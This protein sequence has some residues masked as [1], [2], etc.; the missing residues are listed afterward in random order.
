MMLVPDTNGR[1]AAINQRGCELLDLPWEAILG[2]DWFTRFVPDT[3]AA[4]VA[5]VF[6]DLKAGHEEPA[7][8]M[9][10]EVMTA[11]GERRIMAF[12]NAVL[13]RNRVA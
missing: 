6:E 2:A 9:E 3:D 12:R 11:A 7:E 5:R 13:G 4:E 1:V 10:N 8:Y